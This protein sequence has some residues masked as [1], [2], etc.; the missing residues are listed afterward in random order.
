MAQYHQYISVPHS[1]YDE[2]KNATLFNSYDVDNFPAYQPFQCW[3]YCALLYWQYGLLLITKAGGGTA[4]D[5][6]NV[7]K[8][9]NSKTPFTAIEGAQNIK[10]GDMLVWNTSVILPDGHIG[11]ADEDY[12][13]TNTIRVLGQNQQGI[14]YVNLHNYSLT[15]YLGAFRNSKWQNTPK[16][17]KNTKWKKGFP[18]AVAWHN[19]GY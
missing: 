19:W 3:D 10:K 14:G 13:G 2:W 16:P 5:C 7:S 4:A 6:W 1:S 12:N 11:F 9:A 17:S 15:G 8:N 18:F